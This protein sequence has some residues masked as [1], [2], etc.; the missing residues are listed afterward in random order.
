MCNWQEIPEN[1]NMLEILLIPP[2][3]RT[4]MEVSPGGAGGPG[5]E[6]ECWPW[7]HGWMDG[8][9][10][11]WMNGWMDRWMDEQEPLKWQWQ[12]PAAWNP[13]LREIREV[14]ITLPQCCVP[15]A[16]CRSD[17]AGSRWWTSGRSQG[18]DRAPRGGLWGWCTAGRSRS[19][20]S[21]R[22]WS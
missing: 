15:P 17:R 20:P 6:D 19:G 14:A 18:R 1:Q 12:W 2:G 9:V 22:H 16:G 11:G 3:L 4:S 7:C 10:P 13:M 21:H 8:W 5:W